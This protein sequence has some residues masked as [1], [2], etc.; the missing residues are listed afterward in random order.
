MSNPGG[1]PT[2][3]QGADIL[4]GML[5]FS[6][7]TGNTGL[8]TVPAGRTWSGVITIQCAATVTAAGTVAGQATGVVLTAGVGA[9]PA[10]GNWIRCD[11]LAGANAAGGTVG[12]DASATVTTPFTAQAPVGNSIN[13][14]ANTTIAGG[15][16]QVNYTAV[17]ALQ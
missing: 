14:S 13:I 7:T 10:A 3:P 4:D 15:P 1:R 6:A 11:A 16:G 5:T 9:I 17:G 12:A 2:T 8:I